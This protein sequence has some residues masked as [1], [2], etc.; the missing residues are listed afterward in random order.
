[1][2]AVVVRLEALVDL[3][4]LVDRVD[5]FRDGP[6]TFYLLLS[7]WKYSLGKGVRSVQGHNLLGVLRAMT[8]P[9]ELALEANTVRIVRRGGK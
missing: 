7:A 6:E 2:G 5:C 3:V 1:V 9:A 8:D 4:G